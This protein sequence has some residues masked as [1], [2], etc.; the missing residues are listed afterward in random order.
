MRMAYA[1]GRAEATGST[2]AIYP[3]RT[4]GEV[5]T[6]KLEIYGGMAC[7]TLGVGWFSPAAGVAALGMLLLLPTVVR[8]VRA[9]E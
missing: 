4:C 7:V 1:S 9:R 6:A 8:L 2:S 3:E 5:V